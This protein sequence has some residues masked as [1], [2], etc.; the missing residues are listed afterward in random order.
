MPIL[1]Q[2]FRGEV[3]LHNVDADLPQLF[4][5]SLLPE[6]AIQSQSFHQLYPHL[7]SNSGEHTLQE[8]QGLMV[9]SPHRRRIPGCLGLD[10][11]H[12]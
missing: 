9:C 11:Q 7:Q 12:S 8:G 1:V 10:L 3:V 2:H 4:L 6:Q 5:C